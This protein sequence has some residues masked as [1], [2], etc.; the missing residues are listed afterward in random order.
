MSSLHTIAQVS[1]ETGIAK[2]VLR[3]WESRYGF[4]VPIRDANG[5]RAYPSEQLQRL[6]QIKQ[7]LN[8]G[9]R[10]SQV[11]PLAESLP[12]VASRSAGPHAETVLSVDT[13]HPVVQ[14][15]RSRD[16]AALRENLRREVGRRGLASFVTQDMR[17]MNSCVGRAWEQGLIAIRDE[18]LY[19]EIVQTLVRELLASAVQ[20]Q[21]KPRI[22]LATVTGEAHVLGLLMLEA[23]MSLENAYC[24]SLGPQSPLEEIAR[25]AVDFQADIVALSFSVAFP[26]K[27]ILSQL[28]VLRGTLSPD[29]K[30][31]AG[32]AG[33]GSLERTPRGVVFL[34]LLED[35]TEELRKWR[36]RQ[37]SA[38]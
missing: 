8:D 11:V 19:S 14:W 37:A 24:I 6:K 32:G 36:G 33:V 15:L 18:H 22:L 9:R 28:R 23:L 35:A 17:E 34:P 21:G 30:L 7:L 1:D 25:A 13:L 3:K 5:N 4:P 29:V 20:P 2:E 10:P 26:R 38:A 16:P 31:W 12:P 27:Q